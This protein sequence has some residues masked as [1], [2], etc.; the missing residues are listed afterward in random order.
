MCGRY[1]LTAKE[2]YIRD[3]FG[4]DEDV[5]WSPRWN[6]APTQYAP[7]VRQEPREPR[8]TWVIARWGLVPSWTKDASIGF[9]TT[10]AMS[11][12]AADKPA[13]RDAMRRGRC[14][15]PADGFYEWKRLGPKEKQPHNFG[16]ADDGLFA[17]A[18]LWERWRDESNGQ[19]LETF[20][21]LTT[22]PNSLVSDI[23]NRMPVILRPEDYDRWLDPR[24]TNPAR[25]NGLLKP[26]DAAL[27]RLY[28][29]SSRVNH[30]EYDDAECARE[31]LGRRAMTQSLF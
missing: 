30:V 29:V 25:I 17:F 16:M 22:A 18:G 12:T 5:D 3:H 21:I 1:R 23:H 9:R 10:N 11:E 6:I 24:V 13:F 31:V 19:M 14:L 26:F 2:R 15:I 7:T 20:T 28:P 27:M 8:R 4:L